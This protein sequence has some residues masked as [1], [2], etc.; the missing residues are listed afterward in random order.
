[1]MI[2]Y[3][4]KAPGSIQRCHL[5]GILEPFLSHRFSSCCLN[6]VRLKVCDFHDF[7]QFTHGSE[8]CPKRIATPKYSATF[9][10]H[11]FEVVGIWRVGQV[12]S[13]TSFMGV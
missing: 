8:R 10:A 11:R 4:L 1:M 5:L 7:T 6:A 2:S 3:D 9:K 13:W 12:R